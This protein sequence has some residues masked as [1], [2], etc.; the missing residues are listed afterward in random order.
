ME[1]VT[2]FFAVIFAC[3][4]AQAS[5]TL[6]LA[7]TGD[8]MLG[9]TYPTVRLPQN[10]GRD[11]FLH[12]GPILRGADLALGNF[13]GAMLEGGTCT[14]GS[15]PYAYAFRMPTSYSHLLNEAGFDFMCLANNHSRDFGAEGM[16]SSMECLD[17]EGIA[18]A[19]LP[20]VCENAFVERDGVR[21]GILAF[22]Q[23][24]YCLMH[25]DTALVRRLVTKMR[26]QCDILIVV[27]HGG[28]EGLEYRHVPYGAEYYIGEN[29]GDLR[30]FSHLCIDLGADIVCGHGPHIVRGLELYRNKLI[31][32]SLGNFCTSYGIS[33]VG[34]KGYA[35]ILCVNID[36]NGNF[37]DGKIYGMTQVPG[38][39]PRHDKS[40]KVVREMK[41]LS[42]EDFQ[43]S[44]LLISDDGKL[45]SR[46]PVFVS[47][48]DKLCALQFVKLA[49]VRPINEEFRCEIHRQSNPV[50]TNGK[51]R[52][53]RKL[54]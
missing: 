41:Q 31:A 18:Y 2:L 1:R 53:S 27:F 28:A 39:G 30:L 13:E 21:Y 12:A 25:V 38:T 23:N 11:L 48:K 6:H 37:L 19:G 35:P 42:E 32:Y 44:P 34:I 45:T 43:D 24:R 3:F 20:G 22:G 50:Q 52:K 54:K 4:R 36:K 5:D 8:V 49:H 16:K 9:T 15:G 29:R 47:V 46:Y 33:L 17:R 26:P 10:D 7:F 14:K 51:T 40:G